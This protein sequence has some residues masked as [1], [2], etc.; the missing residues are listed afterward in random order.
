MYGGVGVGKTHLMDLFAK[1]APRQFKC[2]RTHFHDFM[3]DV[4]ARLRDESGEA[5]RPCP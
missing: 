1:A 5:V 3:L 2:R 4:H